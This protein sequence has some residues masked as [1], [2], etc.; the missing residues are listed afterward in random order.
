MKR[1]YMDHSATTPTDPLVVEAMLPYFTEK[2]GNASSLHFFGQ[3][4]AEALEQS[5]KQVAYLIGARPEEI[6]FT[7]GGTESDNLAIKGI[8]YQNSGKGKHI[9]TSVIEHPAVLNTCAH[10][11]KDGFEVTYVPVDSDGIL[12]VA[13][14]ENAIRDDTILITVMHANNEIGTIQPITE[15]SK[16]SKEKGIYFHTDAVQS[17]GKI[18]V[19]VNELGV[20]LLSISSHKIHG[21]K[22]VGAL[23]IKKGTL[24]QAIAHGGEHE[25]RLRAGTENIPGIVGFAK[26][27]TLAKERLAVDSKHLTELRD[28]LIKKVL[29][30]IGH[31]YLN[32]HPTKRLPN[33]ANLRFSFIEGEAMLL[34]LDMK[35][36]AVSTASA[37]SSR[38]L[39]PSHVLKAIGLRPEDAHGSLRFSLGKDNTREE[40]D[41]VVESLAEVVRKLRD[42]SPLV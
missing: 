22:G 7:S 17:V 5:R 28:L 2:F 42:M 16:I 6:I 3:E 26:A 8:A 41:Y 14:L 34:S 25:A 39:E 18:P 35:G 20:D 12:D 4:A 36:I 29:D 19:D 38:S 40:V 33:N 9:I 1:I 15:I 31:S 11:E 23:Y 21:P 10:L 30:S 37:C 27:T 24:I 13:E 32:G